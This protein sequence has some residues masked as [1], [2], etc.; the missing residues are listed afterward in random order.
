MMRTSLHVIAGILIG[1]VLVYLLVTYAPAMA[2]LHVPAQGEGQADRNFQI[3]MF[4]LA[5]LAI[6]LGGL[7][8]YYLARKRR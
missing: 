5:P 8:G 4:Y 7:S 1:L 3:V 6:I 2:G